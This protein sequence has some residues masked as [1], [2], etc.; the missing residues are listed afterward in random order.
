MTKEV[1]ISLKTK[2]IEFINY[3]AESSTVLNQ[4]ERH[5]ALDAGSPV[6]A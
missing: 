4:L 2:S 6:L 1:D 3:L 5:P